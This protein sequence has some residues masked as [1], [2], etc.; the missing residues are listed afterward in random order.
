MTGLK[1]LI[2]FIIL[3]TGPA[4]Y[5]QRVQPNAPV[6]NFRLP[7]FTKEGFRSSLIQGTEANYVSLEQ[8][9]IKDLHLTVFSKDSTD[10]IEMIVLSPSATVAPNARTVTSKDSI[11]VIHDEFDANGQGWKYLND[12]KTIS[13]EKN[14]RVVFKAQLID[15]LK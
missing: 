6:T 5:A 3:A 2:I 15:I 12:Q 8:L 14:V 13:I 9:D 4:A 10:R 7:L 1:P 11:R